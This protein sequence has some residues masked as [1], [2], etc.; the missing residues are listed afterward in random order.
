MGQVLLIRTQQASK[1]SVCMSKETEKRSGRFLGVKIVHNLKWLIQ[2]VAKLLYG[3]KQLKQQQSPS[4]IQSGLKTW[5]KSKH[6]RGF[7]WHC[8]WVF[9][10][11]LEMKE[12]PEQWEKRKTADSKGCWSPEDKATEWVF[13]TSA[14][15]MRWWRS[16]CW[17]DKKLLRPKVSQLPYIPESCKEALAVIY[18][19]IAVSKSQPRNM[20]SP[21]K[22]RQV[23]GHW[24]IFG[25]A[26][27]GKQR[28]YR[29]GA[30]VQKERVR[31]FTRVQDV[32]WRHGRRR[33]LLLFD[34]LCVQED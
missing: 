5:R 19:T 24:G 3:T 32:G 11:L 29:Y 12:I 28:T 6:W 17:L 20:S 34:F 4:Q 9:L 22:H 26:R 13:R 23:P 14:G 8:S 15:S 1:L 27:R 21:K 10:C 2:A 33:D 7:Q 31:L 30:E 25:R 18:E 16:W